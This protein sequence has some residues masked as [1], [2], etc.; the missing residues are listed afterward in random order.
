MC[1]LLYF[2]LIA[3]EGA[4]LGDERGCVLY[5]FLPFY[6]KVSNS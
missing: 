3:P 6:A 1:E 4:K 5:L 2:R